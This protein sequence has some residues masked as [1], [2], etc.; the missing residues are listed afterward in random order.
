MREIY[1]IFGVITN[2]D[3]CYFSFKHFVPEIC[4]V[5]FSFLKPKSETIGNG[6]VINEM[7]VVF[8]NDKCL[9]IEGAYLHKFFNTPPTCVS[10]KDEKYLAKNPYLDNYSTEKMIKKIRESF[11]YLLEKYTPDR[12][13]ERLKKL[14]IVYSGNECSVTKELY[15][16]LNQTAQNKIRV[17]MKSLINEN[18]KF[19]DEKLSDFIK[20]A[21]L[22]PKIEREMIREGEYLR[23]S[24]SEVEWGDVSK[25]DF[26]DFLFS[27]DAFKEE[28]IP[29]YTSYMDRLKEQSKIL[30]PSIL[31]DALC[32]IKEHDD[33]IDT[34]IFEYFIDSNIEKLKDIDSNIKEI[35]DFLLEDE[36]DLANILFDYWW[37][38]NYGKIIAEIIS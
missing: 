23:N 25:L 32:Q 14:L 21:F 37:N 27:L 24:F 12:E 19:Y 26:K 11:L 7:N 35:A 31:A 17:T 38:K 13:V 8:E 9:T 18:V 5:S 1:N 16:I 30:A 6:N 28:N 36:T 34:E 22:K 33:D 3:Q 15:S 2:D 4:S 10:T 20:D 29:Y